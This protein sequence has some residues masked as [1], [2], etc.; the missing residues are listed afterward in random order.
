MKKTKMGEDTIKKNDRAHIV[1]FYPERISEELKNID[2]IKRMPEN[3]R[4]LLAYLKRTN[5][6]KYIEFLAEYVFPR[7]KAH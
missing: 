7:Q 3:D 5:Y 4:R 2:I 1:N 6:D